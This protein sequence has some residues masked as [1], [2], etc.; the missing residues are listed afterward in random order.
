MDRPNESSTAMVTCRLEPL[1][2]IACARAACLSC[3]TS[4]SRLKAIAK[5]CR[6]LTSERYRD[7]PVDVTCTLCHELN[8]AIHNASGLARSRGSLHHEIALKLGFNAVT[9]GFVIL[10]C[11]IG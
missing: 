10:F 3:C 8:H 11:V 5:L 4:K 7:E 9:S 1:R 6:R 2:F